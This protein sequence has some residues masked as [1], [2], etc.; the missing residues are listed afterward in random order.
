LVTPRVGCAHERLV[1]GGVGRPDRENLEIRQQ[2]LVQADEHV[3]VVGEQRSPGLAHRREV[4]EGGAGPHLRDLV[5]EDGTAHAVGA[6]VCERRATR[7]RA[8]QAV[9]AAGTRL[10]R[11]LPPL[12]ELGVL[13]AA[14][15]RRLHEPAPPRPSV[16]ALPQVDDLGP[17]PGR[18]HRVPGADELEPTVGGGVGVE[19]DGV[20]HVAHRALPHDVDH[21]V[22]IE[23]ALGHGAGTVSPCR[24]ATVRR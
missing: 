16:D 9:E 6:Q 2:H 11:L 15:I 5:H 18:A 13:R 8:Q 20:L 21:L 7:R 14:E 22:E 19:P 23:V 1:P 4:V 12:D 10:E 3:S 17:A 24:A